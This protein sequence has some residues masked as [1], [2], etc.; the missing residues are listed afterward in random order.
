[1]PVYITSNICLHVNSTFAHMPVTHAVC[2][3][4]PPYHDRRLLLLLMKVWMVLLVFGTENSKSIFP[5]NKLTDLTP[6]HIFTVFL[7]IWDALAQRTRWHHCIELMYSFLLE[8]QIFKLHFLMQQQTV[9][10]DSS[11]LKYSWAHVGIFNTAAWRFLMQCHLRAQRSSTF[12][13]GFLPCP[14]CT[15]ISLDSLSLFTILCMVFGEFL[16][17]FALW[18]VIFDLFD[19]SLVKFDTKWWSSFA[20]KDWDAPLI[21]KHDTLTYYQFTCLMNCFK[22]V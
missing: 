17:N 3:A 9:W 22:T 14:T 6:A 1:M 11:F 20:C 16:W 10:S 12:N 15:V 19:T 5:G 21:H 18:N 13:W 8:W 4:A 2:S 7:T